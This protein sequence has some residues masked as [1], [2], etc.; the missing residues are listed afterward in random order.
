MRSTLWLHVQYVTNELETVLKQARDDFEMKSNDQVEDI[1][2][3]FHMS[4][5]IPSVSYN[6]KP[7]PEVEQD[8][9]PNFLQVIS[10]LLMGIFLDPRKSLDPQNTNIN[11]RD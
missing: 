6:F 10:K 2:Y 8:E 5:V 1:T 11:Q 9:G 4:I 7:C 3:Q